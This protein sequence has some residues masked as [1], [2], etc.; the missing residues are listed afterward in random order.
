MATYEEDLIE[1]GLNRNEAKVYLSLLELGITKSGPLVKKSKLYRVIL[2]D[3]LQKLIDKGLVNYST[4]NNVKFFQAEP[5]EKL[6]EI[7]KEKEYVA[8][9]LSLKLNSIK[10]QTGSEK[11]AYVYE[12][13]RGIKM[14]QENYFDE[15]RKGKKGEYLMVGASR[16]LHKKLDAFFNYFHERRSRLKISARLLFNENNR[17]FGN[18]KK[19]YRPVEVKFMPKNTITPSW[20]SMYNDMVLI[21]SAEEDEPMAFLIRNKTIAESYRTFFYSMWQLGKK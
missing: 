13:W 3:T 4:K 5:S 20:I 14:A 8:E 9:Q 21:G 1:L 15:M 10:P 19:K 6:I 12:G 17:R 16:T 2:Y 7:T 11:G 18:L